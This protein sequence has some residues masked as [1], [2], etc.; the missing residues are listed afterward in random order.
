MLKISSDTF[1]FFSLAINLYL[2]I[3]ENENS[4]YL[5]VH[6]VM[7]FYLALLFCFK[8]YNIVMPAN[9]QG[10]K[11]FRTLKQRNRSSQFNI[12]QTPSE[13]IFM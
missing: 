9:F 10:R 13:L 4:I 3:E 8:V 2:T 7:D 5:K 1:V 6:R 11:A 12:I